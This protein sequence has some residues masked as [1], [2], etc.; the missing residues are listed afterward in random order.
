MKWK[1]LSAAAATAALAFSLAACQSQTDG[2]STSGSGA[3][4]SGSGETYKIGVIQ[5]APHAALD[6]AREG[7]YRALDESGISYEKDEQNAGGEQNACQTIAESLVNGGNDLIFAIATPAAQAVAGATSDIPIVLTAVTDPADAG[8]VASNDAP[9]GNVT[10]TSDLTPVA[11]QIALVKKIDPDAEKVGFLYSAAEAN[12]EFQIELAKEACEEEG[13]A[14][15]EY[16]ISSTNEIQTVM[17]AAVSEVDVI[18]CPTDNMVANA[19]ATVSMIAN[20][21]GVPVIGGE[22][23][24]VDNGALITFG[25]NYEELGYKTGQ[26]AVKILKGE[27]EPADLPIEYLDKAQ[28]SLKINE[29]TEKAL[30]LDLSELKGE[31]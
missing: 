10:G 17:E 28:C 2:G 3:A 21:N 30:G 9:G 27:A 20:E 6:S 16:S 22:E 11:D 8:L 31:A 4:A 5:L 24:Q 25:I 14:Y 18:Y 19:M 23:G 7:F 15:E 12:S 1:K 29:E 26:M 13:L